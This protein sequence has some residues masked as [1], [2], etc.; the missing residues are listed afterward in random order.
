MVKRIGTTQRKTRHK[1]KAYYKEQG[2]IPLSRYFQ[3]FEPGER[4]NLKIH[5]NVQIG[6]FHSR[7]HGLSGIIGRKKGACY[8][9]SIKDGEKAKRIYVHPIHLN[10]QSAIDKK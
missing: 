7:F 4:V 10:K 6:R 5:P 3:N 2:K 9:V 8:E 1:L